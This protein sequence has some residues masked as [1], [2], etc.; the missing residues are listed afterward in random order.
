MLRDKDR[1]VVTYPGRYNRLIILSFNNKATLTLRQAREFA[2]R[3]TPKIMGC[4]IYKLVE[5]K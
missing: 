4:R 5:V 2:R 1:Y 3:D